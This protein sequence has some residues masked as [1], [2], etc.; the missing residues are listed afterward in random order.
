MK[1]II[2]LIAICVSSV[3]I[4]SS[5]ISELNSE[6]KQILAS[7]QNANTSAELIFLD[8]DS[9]RL[10]G[11]YRKT[12]LKNTLAVNLDE[13]RSNSAQSSSASGSVE[14]DFTKI[15]PQGT[16]NLLMPVIDGVV[17]E[18]VRSYTQMY[19]GAAEASVNIGEKRQDSEGNYTHVS[20]TLE[21]QIDLSKL[22]ASMRKEEVMITAAIVNI[23]VNIKTGF[24]FS[25]Q[26]VNNPAYSGFQNKENA[27]KEIHALFKRL[28]E[29]ADRIVN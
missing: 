18:F 26:I 28:D 6:V 11:F 15:V 4:A 17:K 22:P 27:L 5:S 1:S 16:I 3:A 29:L 14:V 25:A 24:T 23:D 21:L 12:G 2:S 7:F 20:G 13:L 10:N 19:G 8:L 9:L